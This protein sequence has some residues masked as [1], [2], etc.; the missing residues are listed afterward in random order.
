M[1]EPLAQPLP[2]VRIPQQ[3]PFPVPPLPMPGVEL[4][5]TLP[6]KYSS[7][8]DSQSPVIHL[9]CLKGKEK[10]TLPATSPSGP[11]TAIPPLIQ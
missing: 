10:M 1:S 11:T 7:I 5:P 6:G 4:L 3:K 8:P 9:S 2:E